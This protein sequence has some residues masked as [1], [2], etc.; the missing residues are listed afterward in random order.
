MDYLKSVVEPIKQLAPRTQLRGLVDD[1]DSKTEEV[2]LLAGE[3]HLSRKPV[4]HSSQKHC[5]P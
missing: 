5:H 2:L 4:S 1:Y 3:T